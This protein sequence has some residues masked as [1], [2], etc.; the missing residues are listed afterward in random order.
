[1]VEEDKD[2]GN[3]QVVVRVR[4]MVSIESGSEP[5]INVKPPLDEFGDEIIGEEDTDVCSNTLEIKGHD[6]IF[7]K[8]LQQK[9]AQSTCYD[10]C[11]KPLVQ[12]FFLSTMIFKLFLDYLLNF[13]VFFLSV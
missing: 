13:H 11:A 12:S 9:T 2:A 1:M 6:F 3:V 10:M 7:D 4:P 5:C 8:I